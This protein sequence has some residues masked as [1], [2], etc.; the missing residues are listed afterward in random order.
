MKIITLEGKERRQL[1]GG[2]GIE[3]STFIPRKKEKKEKKKM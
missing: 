2:K 1:E 3:S